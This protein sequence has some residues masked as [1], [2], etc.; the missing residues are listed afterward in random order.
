MHR[1]FHYKLWE[2]N[3]SD[4]GVIFRNIHNNVGQ[5]INVAGY[6]YRRFI[7]ILVYILIISYKSYL[8]SEVS[9]NKSSLE[10]LDPIKIKVELF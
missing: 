9:A 4:N 7:N 6:F 5:T 10:M 1:E 2:Y 3:V 8:F